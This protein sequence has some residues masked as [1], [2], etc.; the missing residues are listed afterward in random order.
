MQPSTCRPRALPPGAVRAVR[1]ARAVVRHASSD[2]DRPAGGALGLPSAAGAMMRAVIGAGVSTGV[3]ARTTAGCAARGVGC[4]CGSTGRADGRA[5]GQSATAGTAPPSR[6]SLRSCP[7]R[8]CSPGGPDPAHSPVH[9]LGHTRRGGSG[10]PGVPR[11]GAGV[12]STPPPPPPSTPPRPGVPPGG[13]VHHQPGRARLRVA[14]HGPNG[15]H[16]GCAC[17]GAVHAAGLAA[18]RCDQRPCHPRG[19]AR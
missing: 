7:L 6:C 3:V 1:R 12:R 19:R 14:H 13:G 5:G 9:P 11:H 4:G 18:A 8:C 15:T 16:A 2:A 10:E 17:A